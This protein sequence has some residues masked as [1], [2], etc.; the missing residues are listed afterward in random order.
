MYISITKLAQKAYRAGI[1]PGPLARSNGGMYGRPA[2]AGELSEPVRN[3]WL[4]ALTL[5]RA[6][7]TAASSV[8]SALPLAAWAALLSDGS[9]GFIQKKR[10]LLLEGASQIALLHVRNRNS[11]FPCPDERGETGL[12]AN[13]LM[14]RGGENTSCARALRESRMHRRK[15]GRRKQR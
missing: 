1:E 11:Q 15:Q 14:M 6:A 13:R 7:T 3:A 12:Q 8:A 5:R 2:G 4:L 10:G 9:S